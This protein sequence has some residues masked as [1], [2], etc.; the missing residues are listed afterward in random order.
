MCGY[1]HV[2]VCWVSKGPEVF[3]QALN[4]LSFLFAYNLTAVY[5]VNTFT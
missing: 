5:D 2:S 3:L 1:A 4:T